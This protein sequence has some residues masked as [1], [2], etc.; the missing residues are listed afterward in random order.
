[1]EQSRVNVALEAQ[2]INIYSATRESKYS[3]NEIMKST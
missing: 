3:N 1:M 2:Y